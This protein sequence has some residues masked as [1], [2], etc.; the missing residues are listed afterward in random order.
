MEEKFTGIKNKRYIDKETAVVDGCFFIEKLIFSIK[1]S[2]QT[3][4]KKL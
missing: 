1:Y 3:M 4:E 2:C